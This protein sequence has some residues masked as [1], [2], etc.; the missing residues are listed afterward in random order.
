MIFAMN[1]VRSIEEQLWE[2]H[3]HPR[4]QH[5]YV[6]T[7]HII[8]FVQYYSDLNPMCKAACSHK[9]STF[10]VCVCVWM[11][12]FLLSAF[13]LR[14]ALDFRSKRLS[15]CLHYSLFHSLSACFCIYVCVRNCVYNFLF[16]CFLFF[17]ALYPHSI[18]FSMPSA[19][20]SQ[21]R[22]LCLTK[23]K[24]SETQN[25]CIHCR[26][27]SAI[28]YGSRSFGMDAHMLY[29]AVHALATPYIQ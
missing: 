11:F 2:N 6:Y 16:P 22:A 20:F 3:T 13:A 1:G 17:V 25:I 15:I 9:V 23:K 29:H 12:H 19:M 4:K 28:V 21:S 10:S 8:H 5:T 27:D 26:C 14:S 7:M 18:P 24:G